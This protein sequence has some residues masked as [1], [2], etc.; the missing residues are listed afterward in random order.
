MQDTG[1]RITDE[2]IEQFR[3][4]LI[5]EERSEATIQKYIHEI[6]CLKEYLGGKTIVK[7][8]ILEYRKFLQEQNQATTV[9]VKLSAINCY[10]HFCKLSECK[11]KS[12]RIQRK[13]FVDEE[14]ELLE[15]EY[16]SLLEKAM[17]NRQ[18]RLYYLIMTICGTGIRVSEIRFI[19]VEAVK[20]GCAEIC[21]KGKSRVV[22]IPTKLV[23]KLMVYIEKMGYKNGPVFRTRTGRPMDRSNICHEMKRLSEQSN[24][25]REKVHPHS[26]RHLFARRFYE[27]HNNLA[28]LADVLGHSSMETTRIYVALSAKEHQQTLNAM[29]LVI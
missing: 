11:V 16:Q 25:R 6:I 20:R 9:N 24:V 13:A 14:R 27:D 2:S 23:E 18:Y 28:H 8:E 26:L 17:Q 1:Y 4:Y 7:T 22:V 19:T 29:M 21:L 3:E 12:L 5:E 10:L 15:P